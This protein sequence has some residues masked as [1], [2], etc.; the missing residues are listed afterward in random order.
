MCGWSVMLEN[1]GRQKE[2]G[3]FVAPRALATLLPRRYELKYQWRENVAFALSVAI[4]F[5]CIREQPDRVRGV[6]GKV[7]RKV[8]IP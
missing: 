2:L 5:T 6:F 1:A 8:M 3:M 7:L 4:V